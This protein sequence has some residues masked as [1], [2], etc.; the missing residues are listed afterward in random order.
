MRLVQIPAFQSDEVVAK[1]CDLESNTYCETFQL[2]SISPG[3]TWE[4]QKQL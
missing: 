3:K 1:V 4:Q 2:V